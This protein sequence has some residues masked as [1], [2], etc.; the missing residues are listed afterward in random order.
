[1][2]SVINVSL[3]SVFT[4]N[5]YLVN[6]IGHIVHGN[7]LL[8]LIERKIDGRMEVTERRE[9]RCMQLLDDLKRRREY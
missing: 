1:M 2:K 6:C 7:C 9:R 5:F 4:R 8:K 3:P